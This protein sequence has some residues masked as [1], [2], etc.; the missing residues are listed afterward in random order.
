MNG[1]LFILISL[2]VSACAVDPYFH[3][4]HVEEPAPSL[5]SDA[6]VWSRD[7][8]QQVAFR[9]RGGAVLPVSFEIPL[10]KDNGVEVKTLIHQLEPQ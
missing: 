2:T 7:T 3:G 4:G 9:P 1:F 5:S 6:R 8:A 10:A